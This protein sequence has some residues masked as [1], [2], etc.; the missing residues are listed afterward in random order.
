[1]YIQGYT[2][3]ILCGYTTYIHDIGYTWYIHGYFTY[4]PGILVRTAY[5]WDIH[6]I[7]QAYTENRDSR[8][9]QHKLVSL[10][11]QL[12]GQP[13]AASVGWKAPSVCVWPVPFCVGKACQHAW[14]D[15]PIALFSCVK[16]THRDWLG[17][18]TIHAMPF[19][20]ETSHMVILPVCKFSLIQAYMYLRQDYVFFIPPAPHHRGT[21]SAF[22]PSACRKNVLHIPWIL[23]SCWYLIPTMTGDSSI[24][25]THSSMFLS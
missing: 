2:T 16:I 19:E 25:Q 4:I 11:S 12:G 5:S 3:Y 22:S 17:Q 8:W 10:F 13:A 1:M 14:R 24:W 9:N 15:L 6:G 7:Y 23:Q 21:R 20:R 18:Q